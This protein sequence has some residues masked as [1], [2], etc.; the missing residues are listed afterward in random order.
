MCVPSLSLL[1]LLRALPLSRR[2]ARTARHICATVLRLRRLG[3]LS[4][5]LDAQVKY[6]TNEEYE[7]PSALCEAA[8]CG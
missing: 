7:V 1:R 2:I 6:F 4:T 3:K 8:S 5:W